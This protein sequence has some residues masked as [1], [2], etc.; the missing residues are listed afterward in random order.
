[1][2]EMCLILSLLTQM[3]RPWL[4]AFQSPATASSLAMG[5]LQHLLSTTKEQE[6]KIHT[7]RQA[8][9]TSILQITTRSF[10]KK[11]KLDTFL[12]P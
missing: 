1:M 6:A 4:L 7:R 2:F 8:V 5:I 10:H 3:P 9:N 11:M 12:E